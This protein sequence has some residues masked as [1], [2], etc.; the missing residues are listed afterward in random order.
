MAALVEDCE[1]AH[2]KPS[3]GFVKELADAFKFFDLN[4]D[5]KL[6]LKELSAV[7][8]S[9]GDE[10]AEEDLQQLIKRVDSDGD[11][12]LNLSEFIHLNTQASCSS[13]ESEELAE[14]RALVEAFNKFDAD[15]NGF[16]SSEELH[17]VLAAFGGDRYSLEECRCMIKSVDENGDHLMSLGEFHALMNDGGLEPK[18]AAAKIEEARAPRR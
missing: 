14:N 5:G 11:G 10:V 9:L 16:I 1:T 12:H 3:Q 4:S 7:V 2:R 17:R 15:K 8:R 13:A 6:S 18:A